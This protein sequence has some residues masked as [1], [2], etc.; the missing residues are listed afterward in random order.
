MLAGFV[1]VPPLLSTF[2][3]WEGARKWIRGTTIGSKA[4]T[5]IGKAGT[6]IR[7]A[8]NKD[9]SYELPTIATNNGEDQAQSSSSNLIKKNDNKADMVS[10]V[11][12]IAAN[13]PTLSSDNVRG[14]AA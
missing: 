8:V 2:K 5:T 3:L 9:Q 4:G 12:E 11:V 14:Q 13:M 6:T 10:E 1:A 7:K